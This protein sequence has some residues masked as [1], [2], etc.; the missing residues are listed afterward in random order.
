MHKLMAALLMVALFGCGVEAQDDTVF[1]SVEDEIVGGGPTSGYPA[2][3][4]LYYPSGSLCTG[5]VIAPRIVMTAAH[6]TDGNGMPQAF[7]T[8]TG[9]RVP[10]TGGSVTN[11]TAYAVTAEAV[12]ST[13]DSSNG[14][15]TS[16]AGAL[17]KYRNDIA[18]YR[19]AAVIPNV[20][21]L[22]LATVAPAINR[23]CTV[24]G[25]GRDSEASSY[26]VFRKRSATMRVASLQNT[27]IEM[28]R[29]TGETAPGDSGGPLI[30]GGLV[31]GVASFSAA[32]SNSPT[33]DT[34]YHQRT[35]T[36]LSFVKSTASKWKVAGLSDSNCATGIRSGDACCAAACGACG[37]S[38]CVN[39]PGGADACCTATVAAEAP[40]CS[41]SMPPCSL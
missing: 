16:I 17:A 14:S 35:W 31:Y 40:R 41:G 5:F 28:S 11:L 20:T 22:K 7:Y 27:H 23:N 24:V 10:N 34:D 4:V 38:G 8:G 3:G 2:V 1:Q 29:N 37:G 26:G 36:M 19:L 18:L 13:Y 15:S 30:C 33:A 25:F 6:C 32:P 12:H 39:R 21:P 9:S